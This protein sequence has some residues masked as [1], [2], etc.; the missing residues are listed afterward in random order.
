MTPASS[1]LCYLQTKNVLR[2][3]DII[4]SIEPLEKA[5]AIDKR[6]ERASRE[7]TNSYRVAVGEDFNMV[8]T[9]RRYLEKENKGRKNDRTT[10]F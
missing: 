7:M 1:Y 4:H 6:L 10:I 5:A 9:G 2:I 8:R 3:F